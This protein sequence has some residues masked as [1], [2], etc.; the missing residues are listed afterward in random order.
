MRSCSITKGVTRAA[1]V[2]PEL[3]ERSGTEKLMV[4]VAYSVNSAM[5]ASY[6]RW[7]ASRI[8]AASARP[9][10]HAWSIDRSMIVST[11]TGMARERCGTRHEHTREVFT[12]VVQLAMCAAMHRVAELGIDLANQCHDRAYG[13]HRTRGVSESAAHRM[14]QYVLSSK[15]KMLSRGSA[16]V[17]MEVDDGARRDGSGDSA[18]PSATTVPPRRHRQSSI[19]SKPSTQRKKDTFYLIHLW[20]CI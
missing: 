6:T 1:D 14:L 3:L 8:L 9:A 17:Y 16:V 11:G 10:N 20:H 12:Q 4:R 5:H 13:C 2:A 15:R 7:R 19:C 18:I